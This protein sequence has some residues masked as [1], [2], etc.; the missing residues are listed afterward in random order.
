MT[1]VAVIGNAGGG[2]SMLCRLLSDARKLPH[3]PVDI[4]QWRPGTILLATWIPQQQ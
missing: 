4:I 2:K 3:F 1:R